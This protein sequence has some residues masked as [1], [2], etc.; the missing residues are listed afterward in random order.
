ME[1]PTQPLAAFSVKIPRHR[2]AGHRLAGSAPALS[3]LLRRHQQQRRLHCGQ[4]CQPRLHRH[5][6][7]QRQPCQYKGTELNDTSKASGIASGLGASS[8]TASVTGSTILITC[9]SSS[10]AASPLTH[11]YIVQSG[12]DNIYMAD[13]VTAEPSVGELRYIFRG[14]YDLLPNGPAASDNNGS[15]GA[16]ESSDVYGHSD[17]TTTSK[18]YGSERGKDL[19][20]KGATGTGVGVFMAFGNRESSTGG[21]FVRD[22]ENQGDGAGS[23][24]EIYTY[25]NSGHH[26]NVTIAGT[27]ETNRVNV[28]HGPYAYLFTDGSTPSVPDMSFISSLGLTGYVD[29]SGRG[30]VVLN[31]V[32]GMDTT[33]TYT[34]GFANTTAQYLGE[35]PARPAAASART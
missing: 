29:A 3:R 27:E 17:G 6:R 2:H 20:I 1:H 30:R 23:D 28:L 13:Y 22:I 7:R 8:V 10:I 11:Y 18:Y 4:R 34:M 31:G 35:A 24:Q 12:V 21:P 15:T 32:S 14:K 19:T 25:M 33:Y 16:I 9:V 5:L 26:L